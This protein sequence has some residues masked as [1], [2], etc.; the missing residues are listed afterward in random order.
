MLPNVFFYVPFFNKIC[1][2]FWHCELSP[3]NN[4]PLSRDE[5]FK[6]IKFREA[7]PWSKNQSSVVFL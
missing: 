3:I 5:K 6:D 1:F 2:V 4:V 7:T